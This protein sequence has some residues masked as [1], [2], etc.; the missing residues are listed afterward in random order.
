MEHNVPVRGSQQF[1]RKLLD[2]LIRFCEKG[3]FDI[4]SALQTLV[5]KNSFSL[6]SRFFLVRIYMFRSTFCSLFNLLCAC[7]HNVD[8]HLCV[9]A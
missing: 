1:V 8:V 5:L 4:A 3:N 7:V 2:I 6:G 9:Y